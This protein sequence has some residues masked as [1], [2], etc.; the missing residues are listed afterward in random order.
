MEQEMLEHVKETLVVV[1]RR[2]Q[3]THHL[4]GLYRLASR[5]TR[6]FLLVRCLTWTCSF[7]LQGSYDLVFKIEDRSAT[8]YFEVQSVSETILTANADNTW[9]GD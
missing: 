1:E 2:K 4:V 8:N 7:W 5:H 3:K 9:L 6:R